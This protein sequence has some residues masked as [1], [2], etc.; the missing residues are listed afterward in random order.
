MFGKYCRVR[1]AI[2][3]PPT[4]VL[5]TTGWEGS[6][7][8]CTNTVPV[9][10]TVDVRVIVPRVESG[11]STSGPK[12]D[13]WLSCAS[14]HAFCVMPLNEARPTPSRKLSLFGE[15]SV[16]GWQGPS[17]QFECIPCLDEPSL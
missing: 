10:V 11:I 3:L 16:P 2:P 12:N 7:S 13:R 4:V 5:N 15:T 9:I 6:S 14:H 1:V 17:L 8:E